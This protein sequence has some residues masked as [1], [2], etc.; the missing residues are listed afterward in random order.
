MKSVTIAD[1]ENVIIGL[2]DEIRRSEESRYDHRWHGVLLVAHGMNCCQVADLLGDAPRTVAY[3]ADR[4]EEQGLAGLQEGSRSGRPSKLN[5]D[6]VADLQRVLRGKPSEW[7]CQEIYG[8]E[9]PCRLNCERSTVCNSVHDNAGVCYASGS[10][11]TASR[12]R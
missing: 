4:V 7:A 1:A 8:M 6:Q 3:W 11:A 12:A 10:F 9:K 2:Q 5:A